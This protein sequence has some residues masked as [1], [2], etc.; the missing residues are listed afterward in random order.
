MTGQ[1]ITCAATNMEGIG[2]EHP[3][4][5]TASLNVLCKSID[6]YMLALFLECRSIYLNL[7]VTVV[8]LYHDKKLLCVRT[9]NDVILQT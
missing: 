2:D 9:Q 4:S 8:Q 7:K 3:P 1:N 5:A 6:L